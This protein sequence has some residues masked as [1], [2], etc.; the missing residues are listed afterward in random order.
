MF[1]RALAAAVA[2]LFAA[3]VGTGPALAQKQGGTLKIYHRDNPPSA[4]MHEESTVS[5]TQ[6]F[7]GVYNNLV[8][9]DQ[10][11]K[12]QSLDTVMPE[13]ATSWSWDES[14]TKLTN[15][16]IVAQDELAILPSQFDADPWLLNC[17]N[18]TINLRTGE[19]QPHRRE[20][21]ITMLCPVVFDQAARSELAVVAQLLVRLALVEMGSAPTAAQNEALLRGLGEGAR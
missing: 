12:L 6:P 16:P 20:D 9:F 10:N 2:I 14:K 13:L 21:F 11:K 15:M 7:M 18:G 3:S 8:L 19:L 1:A 17:A 5:V 4:S